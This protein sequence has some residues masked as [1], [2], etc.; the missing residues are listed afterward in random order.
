MHTS[1]PV[2]YP[3]PGLFPL[4]PAMF[5]FTAEDWIDYLETWHSFDRRRWSCNPPGPYYKPIQTFQTFTGRIVAALRRNDDTTRA[6][7]QGDQ[8]QQIYDGLPYSGTEGRDDILQE[9]IKDATLKHPERRTA[10]QHQWLFV[11]DLQQTTPTGDIALMVKQAVH[12]LTTW[13]SCALDI[14]N[15][16]V[17]PN[18]REYFFGTKNAVKD[19]AR[20]QV[21]LG[22]SCWICANDFNTGLHRPQQGPC[23]HTCCYECFQNILAHTLE[24]VKAKYTCAFCRSCL[25]CGVNSCEDHVIAHE[26]ARPYPL[27]PD[28]HLL[29]TESCIADEKLYGMSP[30]RYWAFREQSRGLRSVLTIQV[31]IVLR[32]VDPIHKTRAEEEMNQSV[33]E[34]RKMAMLARQ[35]TLEDLE[36]EQPAVTLKI[37]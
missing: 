13:E 4:P 17:D 3:F 18:D 23:G 19:A 2:R 12:C 20:E 31:G 27:R 16:S 25:V 22:E 9:W 21:A 34:L 37:E 30:K 36:M 33:E 8:L 6:L 10:K 35:L 11:A 28:L 24:F 1:R 5:D 26:K 29:C 15:L 14:E 32:A 7:M